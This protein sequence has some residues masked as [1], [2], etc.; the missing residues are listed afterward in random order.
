MILKASK[1]GGSRQLA[2]H[3]MNGEKNEHVTLHE[4]SGFASNN[5]HSA[6]DEIFAI[7]KGTR[8]S[9]FMFSLSL[10]PPQDENVPA[11]VFEEALERIEKK[12]GLENQPRAIVFH[13]K[14]GRRHAHCVW[15]RIEATK[16]K[17]IDMPFFKNKL[18]DI[19][20]QLYLDH[21]WKMPDGFKDKRLKSPLNYTRAEWQ[22]AA[23]TGQNPKVI[24]STLQ[25]CWALSDNKKGFENALRESGY[26]LAKGDSRGHVVVDVYGEVSSLPRQLALKKKEIEKRIGKA[27]DLPSVDETKDKIS[28]QMTTLFKKF[29][30]EQSKDHQKKL[31][32]FL[33]TKHAM[34]LQHRKDRAA[35][36]AW[37]EQRWQKEE[38]K[39]ISKIRKG[40]KG[41]WDKLNG[42]YWKTR[43]ANEKETWAYHLRDQNERETLI[44][45]Q[46]FGRRP[47][48]RQ[49]N[50]LQT[51][52]E[53]DRKNL[54]RDLSHIT[55]MKQQSKTPTRSQ[56]KTKSQDHKIKRS[57]DKDIGEG[58]EPEI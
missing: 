24:K 16:M 18:K 11:H 54:I 19:A 12:L 50:Q 15:S 36:K 38:L 14:S 32:P 47:L 26:Y 4:V 58:F 20:K 2:H 53:Q 46:I 33:K 40:F 3:L 29:L 23:R 48:Q 10:N 17:A 57:H 37:Q 1:R 9:R 42:R 41:L 13:E 49:L 6:L 44:D 56:I 7:S 52:H 39:R 5:L 45:K 55:N 51:K 8:C 21:G 43:I 28:T 35:Q 30:G 22:Q 31:K 25:E 34:T 27:E